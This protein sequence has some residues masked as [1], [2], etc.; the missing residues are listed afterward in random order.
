MPKEEMR[1]VIFSRMVDIEEMLIAQSE[2]SIHEEYL[3]IKVYSICWLK[4]PVVMGYYEK[5]DVA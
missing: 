5:K 2:L 3:V 4:M 1:A